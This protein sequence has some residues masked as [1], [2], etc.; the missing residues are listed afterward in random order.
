MKKIKTASC[1]MLGVFSIDFLSLRQPSKAHVLVKMKGMSFN[2]KVLEVTKETIVY[3][4]NE[5]SFTHNVV[6]AE[7]G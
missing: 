5:S 3:W 7:G 2:P 1:I 6:C 4:V